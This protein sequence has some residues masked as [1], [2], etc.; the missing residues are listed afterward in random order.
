[1]NTSAWLCFVFCAAC[2][3]FQE[4]G[5]VEVN[6]PTSIRITAPLPPVAETVP[7]EADRALWS[8]LAGPVVLV[9]NG[10]GGGTGVMVHENGLVITAAHVVRNSRMVL[11]GVFRLEEDGTFTEYEWIQAEVIRV[12]RGNDVALLRMRNRPPGLPVARLNPNLPRAGDRVYRVG[13]ADVRVTRGR[14]RNPDVRHDELAHTLELDMIGGPGSS[15][16]PVFNEAGEV[17]GIAVAS[18]RPNYYP[19]FAI[20]MGVIVNT[21]LRGFC[22]IPDSD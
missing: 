7:I 21:I 10:S 6:D 17:I 12:N 5:N 4:N 3:H 8:S 9:I 1:M 19:E 20:P 18:T 14:V 13:F 15:G 22:V 16:G 11:V 2:A